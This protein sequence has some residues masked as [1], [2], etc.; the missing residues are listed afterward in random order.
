MG[1]VIESDVMERQEDEWGRVLG[2]GMGE[3]DYG[4]DGRQ[5]LDVWGSNNSSDGRVLLSGGEGWVGEGR[6]GAELTR[7]RAEVT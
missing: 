7:E 1:R 6:G 2:Q 4:A 3:E 5:E